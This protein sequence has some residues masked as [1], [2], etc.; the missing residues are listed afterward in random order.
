MDFKSNSKEEKVK[1]TTGQQGVVIRMDS[2]G[3]A[4]IKFDDHPHKEWVC[5]GNFDKLAAIVNEP[6]PEPE[7][8]RTTRRSRAVVLEQPAPWEQQQQVAPAQTQGFEQ[9]LASL[10]EELAAIERNQ[11]MILSHQQQLN[12]MHS[13][14]AVQRAHLTEKMSSL[15]RSLGQASSCQELQ[16]SGGNVMMAPARK[17][18]GPV[19]DNLSLS[20]A[21]TS[22][23]SAALVD[24]D[25]EIK[26][27]FS[28]TI[29]QDFQ[30]N[31]KGEKVMLR[32]GQQGVVSRVDDDGDALIKF[33]DHQH[34]EWV[35]R[36]NFRKLRVEQRHV[37][38]EE[39]SH[40]DAVCRC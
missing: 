39:V 34:K 19:S 7:E 20:N 29:L 14:A 35:A 2:D 21:S 6:A 17:S 31:S 38:V 16:V 9:Q 28:V 11:A 33:D 22:A 3:D 37:E 18:R 15:R 27:G 4:L 5:K 40:K 25:V 13:Q 12:Q 10:Q 30:C 23:G 24:D 1:L 32:A 8:A 36:P 26:A